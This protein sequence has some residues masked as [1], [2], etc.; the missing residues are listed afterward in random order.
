MGLGPLV[1]FG[2]KTVKHFYQDFY[3]PRLS[4]RTHMLPPRVVMPMGAF[5][6]IGS[7]IMPWPWTPAR[8]SAPIRIVMFRV[9]KVQDIFLF[10]GPSE[11]D[12]QDRVL[13]K[14]SETFCV[15]IE[16]L[17]VSTAPS[18][19]PPPPVL[20]HPTIPPP[21]FPP[22]ALTNWDWN[23]ARESQRSRLLYPP[24]AHPAVRL[25]RLS[26]TVLHRPTASPATC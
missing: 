3:L 14:F 13:H 17:L 1:S 20:V 21:N 7:S 16:K 19:P 6:E 2:T 22:R 11:S 5:R 26:V 15:E 25:Q 9:V 18:V 10:F 8:N 24:P 23:L 4:S 12:S